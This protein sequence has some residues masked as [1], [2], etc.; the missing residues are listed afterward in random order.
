MVDAGVGEGTGTGG[1]DDVGRGG[2]VVFGATVVAADVEIAG[3]SAV[4]LKMST[5]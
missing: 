2:K 3:V 4:E 5:A 1:E